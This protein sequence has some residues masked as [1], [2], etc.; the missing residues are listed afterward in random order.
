[1]NVS[2]ESAVAVIAASVIARQR[3]NSKGDAARL[4]EPTHA[5]NTALV[6]HAIWASD[7]T[8][9]PM[10]K[11]FMYL[12]AIIDWHSPRGARHHAARQARWR[13]RQHEKVTYHRLALRTMTEKVRSVV[14]SERIDDD[15]VD[16]AHP[17]GRCDFCHRPLGR[18][19]RLGPLRRGSH[20]HGWG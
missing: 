10:A 17:W 1:M 19:I 16:E 11:G 6:G 12:V 14:F 15:I 2:C 18:F 8:F 7:I 20:Q 5:T 13:A 4:L 3:V 9:C